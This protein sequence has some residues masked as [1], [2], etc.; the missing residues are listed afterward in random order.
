MNFGFSE[1]QNILR[2]QVARFMRDTCPMTMVRE[3]MARADG[4][5]R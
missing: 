4:F 1:E 3:L 2:E 5:D